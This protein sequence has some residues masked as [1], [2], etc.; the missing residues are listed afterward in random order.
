MASVYI[1]QSETTWRF[2]HRLD[3]TIWKE[4]SSAHHCYLHISLFPVLH[5]NVDSNCTLPLGETISHNK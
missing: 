1:L 2:S 5:K 3:L 4:G